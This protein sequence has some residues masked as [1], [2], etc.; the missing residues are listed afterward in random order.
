LISHG[1]PISLHPNITPHG[2]SH[3]YISGRSQLGH[4]ELA[5]LC[6]KQNPSLCAL[7]QRLTTRRQDT[8][9]DKELTKDTRTRQEIQDKALHRRTT[10]SHWKAKPKTKQEY[11]DYN[12][13]PARDIYGEDE[14][15]S[16]PCTDDGES[17]GNE[18]EYDEGGSEDDGHCKGGDPN[19]KGG[20]A[21]RLII[22]TMEELEEM[23]PGL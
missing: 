5:E 15:W 10:P 8:Q 11:G 20:P 14:D 3:A 16:G 7:E 9:Q 12:R 23:E 1:A 6:S 2:C 19:N 21:N 13:R 22:I 17:D 4:Q 18:S